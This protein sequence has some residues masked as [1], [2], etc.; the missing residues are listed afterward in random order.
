MIK[1]NKGNRYFFL[2]VQVE[3]ERS[4]KWGPMSDETVAKAVEQVD[5][6][7]RILQKRGI[8]VNR[9]MPLDIGR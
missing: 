2:L 8:R 3:T 6:F 9:P 7:A 5:D 4:G 1:D